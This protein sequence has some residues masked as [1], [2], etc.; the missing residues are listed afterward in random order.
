MIQW[1][2]PMHR[3][4]FQSTQPMCMLIQIS[5]RVIC[6]IFIQTAFIL[7]A[8]IHVAFQGVCSSYMSVKRHGI[9]YI[10]FLFCMHKSSCLLDFMYIISQHA[11][12]KHYIPVTIIYSCMSLTLFTLICFSSQVIVQTSNQNYSLGNLEKFFLDIQYPDAINIS[13]QVPPVWI[14]DP[15]N[16]P[17]YCLYGTGVPTPEQFVYGTDEFPDTFPKTLFGDGDGTVNIR[18]LKAC[19]SFVDKQ[20]QPVVIKSFSNA[21]HMGIIGDTRLI[22]YVKN[23]I[24]SME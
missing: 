2:Y 5:S 6:L 15:P 10:Q 17:L 11:T 21:E 1:Q 9:K 7:G 8:N 16:V 14:D 19:H 18:S 3:S 13:K 12:Q 23:L 4:C 22:E 24:S 20:K